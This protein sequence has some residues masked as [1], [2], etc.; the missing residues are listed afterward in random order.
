MQLDLKNDRSEHKA[1][2]VNIDN[3]QVGRVKGKSVSVVINN[4]PAPKKQTKLSQSVSG[5][6][7]PPEGS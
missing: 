2:K 7:H 3:K 5:D 1:K 6:L 4:D